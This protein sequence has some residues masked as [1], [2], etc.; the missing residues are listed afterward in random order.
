MNFVHRSRVPRLRDPLSKVAI[1]I[2]WINFLPSRDN[3]EM[4]TLAPVKLSVNPQ[5]FRDEV[6]AINRDSDTVQT[7]RLINSRI[8]KLVKCKL[9]IIK[10]YL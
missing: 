10:H 6:N 7:H 3:F 2:V 8:R 5:L 4:L 1:K 9:Q